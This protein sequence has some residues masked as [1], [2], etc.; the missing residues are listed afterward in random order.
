[1]DRTP[2]EC[3]AVDYI[4][5]GDHH[6]R[7]NSS[8]TGIALIG[9]NLANPWRGATHGKRE[10]VEV[11]KIAV[12][13]EARQAMTDCKA[14]DHKQGLKDCVSGVIDRAYKYEQRLLDELYGG[15]HFLDEQ[16][17]QAYTGG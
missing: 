4:L 1:M 6:S 11:K 14:C 10:E 2:Y 9:G 7:G 17:K 16:G 8:S 15:P 5:D 3:E 12:S 13:A